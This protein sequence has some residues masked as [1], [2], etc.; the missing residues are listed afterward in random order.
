M[1]ENGSFIKNRAGGTV[2]L[3]EMAAEK[4]RKMIIENMFEAGEPLRDRKSVV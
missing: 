3:A 4:I 1:G 2:R